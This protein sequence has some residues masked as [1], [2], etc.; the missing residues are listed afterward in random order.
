MK[1]TGASPDFPF[2]GGGIA[3]IQGEDTMLRGKI[4]LLETAV[5]AAMLDQGRTHRGALD[6]RC[7]SRH[8]GA[9]ADH[10]HFAQLDRRARFTGEL[11][12]GDHIVLGDLVLLAAGA[13]HCKH[14]RN[15]YRLARRPRQ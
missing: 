13:D 12:D 15:R 9:V 14:D 2:N 4:G 1:T 5:G 3:A 11:F 8:G 10:Q 6:Q 7:A